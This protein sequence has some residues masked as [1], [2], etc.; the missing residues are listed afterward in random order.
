MIAGE[1]LRGRSQRDVTMGGEQSAASH[2]RE[3]VLFREARRTQR[4]VSNFEDTCLSPRD[5]RARLYEFLR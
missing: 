2:H 4:R 3:L 5:D 1:K